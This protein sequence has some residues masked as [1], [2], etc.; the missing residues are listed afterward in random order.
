MWWFF[1]EETCHAFLIDELHDNV[2]NGPKF[3]RA[4][5]TLNI[6]S[7][8]W[9]L[10]C[11]S[12]PTFNNISVI[13]W[14]SVLLV[15]KTWEPDENHRPVASHWQTLSHNAVLST[16][17]HECMAFELT[18]LLVIG[19]DS[20]DSCISNYHTIMATTAPIFNENR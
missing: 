7:K 6:F 10:L 11:L 15:E 2:D 17:R 8:G 3:K 1:H 19:T 9:G 5:E 13:L 4:F 14:W 16:S 12:P 20:T 18:T